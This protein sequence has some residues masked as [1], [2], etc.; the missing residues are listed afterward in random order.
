LDSS[1][2]VDGVISSTSAVREAK[3]LTQEQGE[4]AGNLTEEEFKQLQ[5]N[6]RQL[7]H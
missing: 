2:K 6:M 1:K 5:E 7:I 4:V 3:G